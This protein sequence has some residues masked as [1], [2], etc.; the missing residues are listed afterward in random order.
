MDFLRALLSLL[1]RRYVV[2][3][4][5]D[6]ERT[7]CRIRFVSG[8]PFARRMSLLK[9]TDCWLLDGGK[10][11]GPSYVRRW[12]PYQPFASKQWPSYSGARE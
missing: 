10:L 4:D 5:H 3:V 2:L 11:W 12:E 8:R 7:I 9:E 6:C 1:G